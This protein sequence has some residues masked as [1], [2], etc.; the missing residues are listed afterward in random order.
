MTVAL[1]Q[2]SCHKTNRIC[3]KVN[4]SRCVPRGTMYIDNAES[5]NEVTQRNK[6]KKN[7]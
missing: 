5:N 7:R 1:Q 4:Y 3:N 2:Q 6:R